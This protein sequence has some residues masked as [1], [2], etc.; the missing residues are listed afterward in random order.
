MEMDIDL[1]I[2]AAALS[3]L[4]QEKVSTGKG[5]SL[6]ALGDSLEVPRAKMAPIRP[7]I[8]AHGYAEQKWTP[9]GLELVATELV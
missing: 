4:A 5:L 6:D 2:G 9:R 8:T 1:G 7:W 3:R